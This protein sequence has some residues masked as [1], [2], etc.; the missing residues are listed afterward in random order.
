M[1]LEKVFSKLA[2]SFTK[3]VVIVG[4]DYHG[5]SSVVSQTFCQGI[6]SWPSKVHQCKKEGQDVDMGALFK[7]LV[8]SQVVVDK[9]IHILSEH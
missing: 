2:I 1:L 8:E 7:S 9:H 4:C 5:E 3:A 6:P